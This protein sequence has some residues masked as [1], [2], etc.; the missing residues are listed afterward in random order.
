MVNAQ[1]E[2]PRFEISGHCEWEETH[3]SAVRADMTVEKS[4]DPEIYASQVND[5]LIKKANELNERLVSEVNSRFRSSFEVK[6]DGWRNFTGQVMSDFTLCD[7][8]NVWCEFSPLPIDEPCEEKC[9]TEHRVCCKVD[10]KDGSFNCPEAA[11]ET[12]EKFKNQAGKPHNKSLCVQLVKA[13]KQDNRKRKRSLGE[14]WASGGPLTGT[15]IDRKIQQEDD[16]RVNDEKMVE[17]AVKAVKVIQNG[18]QVSINSL[19]KALCYYEREVQENMVR[20]HVQNVLD[21]VELVV[22]S[23]TDECAN[24]LIP[25]G[26][27]H[28]EVQKWCRQF[29]GDNEVCNEPFS[30]FTCENEK[31]QLSW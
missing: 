8:E 22:T 19:G 26:V 15:Y 12:L 27:P 31:T 16:K 11:R 17:K 29:S 10:Q 9:S 30:L 13:K 28:T 21:H 23:N 14:Y 3:N 5:H 2:I 20:F 4:R 7:S 24:G 25:N 1:Y 6:N 18:Q